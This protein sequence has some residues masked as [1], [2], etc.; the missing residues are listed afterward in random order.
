MD[1]QPAR[2][3]VKTKRAGGRHQGGNTVRKWGRLGGVYYLP[4]RPVDP[5][6]AVPL[7]TCELPL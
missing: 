6:E 5:P 2:A 4:I 7:P 1:F 3:V